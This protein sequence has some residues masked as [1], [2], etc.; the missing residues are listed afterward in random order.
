[1]QHL[2]CARSGKTNFSLADLYATSA[3]ELWWLSGGKG[4]IL[5]ELLCAVLRMTVVHNGVH[6]DMSSS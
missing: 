4:G 6:T 2:T 5:S 1:M 3:S